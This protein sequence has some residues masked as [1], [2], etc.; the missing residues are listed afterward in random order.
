MTT[1]L[2]C[3]T[4]WCRQRPFFQGKQLGEETLI[5]W[6]E[7]KGCH[8]VGFQ[9]FNCKCHM[10]NSGWS[11]LEASS[12]L[13]YF[14]L[15]CLVS[16]NVRHVHNYDTK[17][18]HVC[19]SALRILADL[20]KYAN[21]SWATPEPATFVSDR[22][23]ISSTRPSR[24]WQK[25]IGSHWNCPTCQDSTFI[26][27]KKIRLYQKHHLRHQAI[28]IQSTISCDV[29]CNQSPLGLFSCLVSCCNFL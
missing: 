9:P 2:C 12:R 26:D 17:K 8:F 25:C 22:K 3:Q 7:W 11:F 18:F 27:T 29:F 1:L 24:T 6:K 4:P 13:K 15:T 10:L 5:Q 23:R 28:P 20:H 21:L 16:P 14:K 19:D